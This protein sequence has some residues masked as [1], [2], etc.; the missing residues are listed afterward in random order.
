MRNAPPEGTESLQGLI[1]KTHANC[2][3]TLWNK[4]IN[5]EKKVWKCMM[6]KIK[7]CLLNKPYYAL[8]LIKIC[9]TL[10]VTLNRRAR[11]FGAEE[12]RNG[13]KERG[14][15]VG[16]PVVLSPSGTRMK[17][18]GRRRAGIFHCQ[19][20]G[21]TVIHFLFSLISGSALSLWF[22]VSVKCQFNHNTQV[23][24]SRERGELSNQ[25]IG[26]PFR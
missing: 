15:T 26:S 18:D 20:P 14:G 1:C 9:T 11:S 4:K 23:P 13:N 17:H 19:T 3:D 21:G 16:W 24:V 5:R 8:D 6:T 10:Q 22:C 7:V 12:E 2:M 25:S